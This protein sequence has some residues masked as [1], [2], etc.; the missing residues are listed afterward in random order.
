MFRYE[1][2]I[3]KVGLKITGIKDK[4]Q[5]E[6]II[7]ESINDE[8]VLELD[9]GIMIG[10]HDLKELEIKSNIKYIPNNFCASCEKLENVKLPNGVEVLADEAFTH[11][12]SLKEINIPDTVKCLKMATFANCRS[13]CYIEL[14]KALE[15]IGERCFFQCNKLKNIHIGDNVKEIGKLAFCE[16]TSLEEVKIDSLNVI[17]REDV[18]YGCKNLKKIYIPK[19][20]NYRSYIEKINIEKF[21]IIQSE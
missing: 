21:E 8:K 4:K 12:V 19:E 17:F 15:N 10:C 20:A 16:C 18:F 14:S 7:P 11:C 3:P 2:R 9:W 5:R 13:L 6:I 1:S